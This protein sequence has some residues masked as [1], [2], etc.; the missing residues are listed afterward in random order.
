MSTKTITIFGIAIIIVILGA[1]LFTLKDSGHSSPIEPTILEAPEGWQPLPDEL[2][3]ELLQEANI[4]GSL[5]PDHLHTEILEQIPHGNYFINII[6]VHLDEWDSEGRRCIIRIG[7]DDEESGITV[8]GGWLNVIFSRDE[9][10]NWYI[11][12]IW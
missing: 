8:R 9:E 11:N 6:R 12:K 2:K 3:L 10:Q 1:I 7:V 4:E 5:I